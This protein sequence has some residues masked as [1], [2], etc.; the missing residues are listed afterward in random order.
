MLA[1]KIGF[2]PAEK[3]YAGRPHVYNCQRLSYEEMTEKER[4]EFVSIVR[5]TDID[6][7]YEKEYPADWK[8]TKQ[9]KRLV[10]DWLE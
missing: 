7:E 9:S 8:L 1:Q 5:K 4:E 3:Y 6:G 10:D 2:L